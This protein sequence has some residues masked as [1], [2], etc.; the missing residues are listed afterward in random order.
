[1]RE[2]D[3][4]GRVPYT[5]AD[6]DTAR[7]PSAAISLQ[8]ERDFEA[9]SWNGAV[10]VKDALRRLTASVGHRPV[11]L[12]LSAGRTPTLVYALL[13]SKLRDKL[14]W[15]KVAIFQMDEYI[16][17]TGGTE[18]FSSFLTRAVI[19]PL[20]IR[21]WH[22][23][24][25]NGKPDEAAWGRAIDHHERELAERGGIDLVVHGIGANGH[26]GFNEPGSLPSSVGRI[27]E[28]SS[29][30]RS[31]IGQRAPV[32]GVTMGLASLLGARESILLAS[33]TAKAQAV[34]GAIEGPL[35]A[36]CP[37]SWLRLGAKTTVIVDS[38]AGRHLHLD[39]DCKHSAG[40]R[41]IGDGV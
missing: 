31:A 39:L 25:V 11:N 5:P 16:G 36:D 37:A 14:N 21:D 1:M 13:T 33:G 6:H 19:A 2:G 40:I 32:K 24:A 38:D 30:T 3:M 10:T 15:S 18:I 7:S 34:A 41:L 4:I 17:A 20:G 8:V 29:S 9:M 12:V 35:S 23:L 27:T 22:P 28:L 26:L